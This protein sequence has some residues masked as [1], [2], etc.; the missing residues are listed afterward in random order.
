MRA[1]Y[2]ILMGLILLVSPVAANADDHGVPANQGRVTDTAG[3]F[4]KTDR[5]VLATM[6]K[7][8]E[9]SKKEHPQVLILTTKGIPNNDIVTFGV[10]VVEAWK[11]GQKGIDN[12][13]LILINADPAN[14]QV[15]FEV[16]YGLEPFIT[17]TRSRNIIERRMVPLLKGQNPNWYKASVE[18]INAIGR[19]IEA[20]PPPKK[21][22]ESSEAG[23]VIAGF[24]IVLFSIGAFVL[25][26]YLVARRAKR[27]LYQNTTYT[28]SPTYSTR[29]TRTTT[30]RRTTYQS[31]PQRQTTPTR[32]RDDDDDDDTASVLTGALIGALTSGGSSERRNT[33]NDWSPGGGRSGGGGATV[34]INDSDDSPSTPSSSTSDDD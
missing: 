34:S 14:P 1:L 4:S 21:K 31:P 32:R 20:G 33:D 23:F 19:N 3:V 25:F 12:G 10:K 7:Q 13:L 22:E 24:I 28:P 18:A 2:T 27:S 16:G 30:T 11:P 17:D 15:R 8:L 5:D 26:A 29:T 6:L 9:D